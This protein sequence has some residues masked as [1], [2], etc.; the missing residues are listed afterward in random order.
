MC[1]KIFCLVELQRGERDVKDERELIRGNT[2]TIVLAVLR[3]GAFHGY[4]LLREVNRRMGDI[5]EFKQGTLYPVLYALEHDDMIRGQWEHPPGE[6]PRKVYHI[7][8]AG[9]AELERR[10]Q[11][12]K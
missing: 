8:P 1:D 4:A 3:D 5:L 6:R 11:T 9:L 7:T 2:P 12:W 10:L